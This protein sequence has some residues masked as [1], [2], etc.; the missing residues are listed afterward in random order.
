MAV[1]THGDTGGLWLSARH[2][3]LLSG[4][5][6]TAGFWGFKTEIV[7]SS[8]Y[9]VLITLF[10]FLRCY[11]LLPKAQSHNF[12]ILSGLPACPLTAGA[13]QPCGAQKRGLRLGLV[14]QIK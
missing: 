1:T 5:F 7:F 13:S 4:S 2:P 11:I 8:N 10:S 3:T 14:N 6:T 12:V 9:L